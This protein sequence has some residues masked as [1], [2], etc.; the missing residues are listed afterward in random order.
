MAR[1]QAHSFLSPLRGL[2]QD[3]AK[4]AQGDAK[5]VGAG[6]TTE[7]AAAFNVRLEVEDHAWCAASLHLYIDPWQIGR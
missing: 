6:E 3:F 2:N 5:A 1:R 4:A 7:L